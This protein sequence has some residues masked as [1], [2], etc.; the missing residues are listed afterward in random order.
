VPSRP[1]EW[2]D[3][4][5][6]EENAAVAVINANEPKARSVAAWATRP[7]LVVPPAAASEATD[8]LTRLRSAAQPHALLPLDG[9]RERIWGQGGVPE[10]L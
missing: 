9:K 6:A 8:T 3:V 10:L 1:S 7:A 5:R 4:V 2:L